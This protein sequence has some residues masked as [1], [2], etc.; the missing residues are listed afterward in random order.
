LRYTINTMTH[1]HKEEEKSNVTSLYALVGLL[2]GAF[3]GLIL[4]SSF[5]WIPILA[6]FGFLFAGFFYNIIVKGRADA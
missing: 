1:H 6:I 4:E 5:V 2:S 3:V